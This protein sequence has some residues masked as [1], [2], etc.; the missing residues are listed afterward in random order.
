MSSDYPQLASLIHTMAVLRG[1]GGCPW[2]GEQ[3]HESLVGFLLEEVFELIEALET[4]SREDIREEL[5]DVLYQILFHADIASAHPTDPFTI[6]DVAN[7]VDQKMRERHPHV[8]ADGDAKT[9]DEVISRWEEIKAEQKDHRESVLDGIPEKLPALARA[10]SIIKRAG[11]QLPG[12]FTQFPEAHSSGNRSP[13]TEK[14][15][16]EA[17]FALVVQAKAQG[18][19]AER[20]LRAHVREVEGRVRAGEGDQK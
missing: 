16:G 8:F 10:Q 6:E 7:T 2:D 5:G 14:E 4:G 9:V 15:L 20:A 3:T 1:P 12:H 19:D 18:L 17:L 11:N 13:A